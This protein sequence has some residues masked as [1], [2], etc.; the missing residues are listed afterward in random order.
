M[1]SSSVD[2]ALDGPVAADALLNAL[3]ARYPQIARYRSMMILAVNHTYARPGDPVRPGDELAV[4]T[5]VSGG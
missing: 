5:P 2:I 4:I 1:Q 3:C